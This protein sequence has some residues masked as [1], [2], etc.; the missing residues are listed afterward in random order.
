MGFSFFKKQPEKMPVRPAAVPK[1][2]AQVDKKEAEPI[3]ANAAKSSTAV[4]APSASTKG[5]A[6]P[7]AVDSLIDFSDF[8]LDDRIADFAVDEAADPIDAKGEEA[9]V[10][11]ANGQDAL[12][13]MVLE[14]GVDEFSSRQGERLWRMLLDFYRLT[15]D[16]AAFD[17]LAMRFASV[18]E[19]SPPIWVEAVAAKSATTS[20]S[21]RSV[22][23]GAFVGGLMADN[24]AA[25]ANIVKALES[26][27]NASVDFSKM[28]S[29]DAEG[30]AR[31]LSL[32][33]KAR[34]A[35]QEL[36]LVDAAKL[37]AMLSEKIEP[38]LASDKPCWLLQMEIFQQR[39]EQFEFEELAINYAV[40]FEES[41]PSWEAKRVVSNA[42]AAPKTNTDEPVPPSAEPATVTVTEAAVVLQG[43]IRNG[44]FA[45]I[46][47]FASRHTELMIDCSKLIRMDFVSAASLIN[48]FGPLCSAKKQ[49]ILLR[50]NYLV[51]ELFRVL[52][53]NALASIK[54]AKN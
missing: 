49:I 24:E 36:V 51:A 33:G 11:F 2:S 40:T 3:A 22:R 31:L 12:A 29:L 19:T 9:A 50:P 34:K 39:G 6:E 42:A 38:G 1:G 20:A 5:A 17:A 23:P 47:D 53:L 52:G 8:D 7:V 4:K 14:A 30:C 37:S 25:F 41:P 13:R 18:F 45:E 27:K 48:I 54:L 44:R 26:G 43:E 10:L 46:S 35:G 32:W 16:R 15:G 28:T 21:G